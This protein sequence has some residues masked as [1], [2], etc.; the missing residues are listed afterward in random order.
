MLYYYQTILRF[1]GEILHEKW[2]NQLMTIIGVILILVA[3]YPF[4]KPHIDSYLHDKDNSDKMKT[5]IK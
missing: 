4:A 5:M 3:I 1:K 2:T